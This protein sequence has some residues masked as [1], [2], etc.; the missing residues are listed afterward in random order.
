M[1]RQSL[2]ATFAIAFV[3]A[4][5]SCA[6]HP[7]A[8]STA[9]RS[10][11][12]DGAAIAPG[13]GAN[14]QGVD[15]GRAAL[16]TGVPVTGALSDGGT[17]AGT[18]TATHID[19]DRDTRALRM[20]GTLVGSATTSDGRQVAITQTFTAPMTLSRTA[21]SS[22]VFQ[23]TAMATCDILFLDLGPLHLDLLGLTVDLNEV[24][25]DLNAVS[26]AGNL[27][28]NLLCAVL[29]LLDIPGAI[30]GVIQL[31]DSINN[32]LAGLNPGG[33]TGAALT[34]PATFMLS[35]AAV[36]QA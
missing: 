28:G 4:V 20:T 5:V 35:P 22:A 13:A 6:D 30:A 29:G 7:T 32:L 24:I 15:K 27:L 19:V 31:I 26:G 14:K 9:Q 10:T 12:P 18:L 21:T 1:Y 25:L 36:S 17:F 34:V 11:A 33:I 8:P 3:T 16:L 2:L 23:T